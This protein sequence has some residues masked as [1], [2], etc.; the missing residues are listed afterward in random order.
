MKRTRRSRGNRAGVLAV[1]AAL[2]AGA[3]H[4]QAA[5]AVLV[6]SHGSAELRVEGRCRVAAPL[7]IAWDVLT[8]YD[9]IDE[10]VGSM[11]E[12]RIRERGEGRALVEQVAVGRLL[13]FS[14]R[15]HVLLDVREEP[16][17]ALHFED[18]L[19]RDFLAYRGSWRL[20]PQGD[21]VEIV[22]RL[23]ARP[24]FRVPDL[25]ARSLFRRAVTGLLAEVEAEILRRASQ[26]PAAGAPA[27]H[28]PESR[29]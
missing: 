4:A 10:F 9:R 11:R 21:Q 23:A 20:L 12:S 19:G 1:A 14:R 5:P 8:D 6:S 13:I 2:V 28:G 25:V 17:A 3:V 16:D 29:P 15:L 22:Y 27:P 24:A 26:A 7:S 18:R